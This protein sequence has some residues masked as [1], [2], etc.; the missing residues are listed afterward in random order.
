MFSFLVTGSSGYIG[1]AFIKSC[2]EKYRISRFYLQSQRFEDI[3]CFVRHLSPAMHDKLW[4]DLMINSTVSKR[5]LRLDLP[6]DVEAGIA[7]IL[8]SES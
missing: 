8:K 7:D 4:G 1:S 3:N 6:V 5:D 2:A